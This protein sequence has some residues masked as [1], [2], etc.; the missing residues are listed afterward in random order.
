MDKNLIKILEEFSM[1][2]H[3]WEENNHNKDLPGKID[4]IWITITEILESNKRDK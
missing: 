2:L 1:K 3:K 4:K